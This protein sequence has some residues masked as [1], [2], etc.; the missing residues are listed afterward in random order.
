VDRPA[1]GVDRPVG[2][3][4]KTPKVTGSV[5]CNFSVLVDRP[6]CTTGPSVTAL[7]DI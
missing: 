2:E 3:N 1:S 7:S 6:G 4:E 5:K